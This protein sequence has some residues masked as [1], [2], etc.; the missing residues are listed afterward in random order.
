MTE[1]T[2][3]E[4]RDAAAEYALDVLDGSERSALAAH[5]LRCPA[6]REEVES[7]RG[8]AIR[9]LELVPGTEPP[10]GFDRRVLSRV[11]DTAPAARPGWLPGR[12]G[13]ALSG[14]RPRL[15]VAIATIAAAAALIFGSLGWFMGQS[16]RDTS[17]RVLAEAAF[18]QEGRNVGSVYAYRGSAYANRGA[19]VWLT[20]TVRG[21]EGGPKVTC[22]LIGADGSRIPLGSFD[23]VGG[24]GSWGAPDRWGLSG[25]TGAAL[26]GSD[27][28]VI[29]TAVFRS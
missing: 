19:P 28:Q 4:V 1:L 26:V 5:L 11:R 16:D 12:R 27:G 15:V 3:T 7:M 29:A 23:L 24:S 17:N 20:M 25:I 9:L 18:H 13:R 14:R 8:V 10:L 2:C 21:V 6:C 22:D